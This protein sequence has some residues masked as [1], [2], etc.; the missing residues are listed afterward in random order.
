M[1]NQLIREFEGYATMI[2]SCLGVL[3]F[4]AIPYN[5][6]RGNKRDVLLHGIVGV[7]DFY[8][9]IKHSRRL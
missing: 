1:R 6:A 9:A 3:H 4:V 7:Y 2:H 8:S 5:W